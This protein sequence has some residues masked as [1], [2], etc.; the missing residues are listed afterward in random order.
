MWR[1]SIDRPA[2]LL[3]I[4][5]VAVC[6]V[7]LVVIAVVTR[8][9]VDRLRMLQQQIEH[10]S[11]IQRMALRVQRSLLAHPDAATNGDSSPFNAL[12]V[13]LLEL[14]ARGRALD[15]TS[16]ERLIRL[17]ELLAVDPTLDPARLASAVALV[18]EIVEA[19]ISAQ[20]DLWARIN[21]DTQLELA[22]V[23]ALCIVLP[24][25]A[26]LAAVFIRRRILSPLDDLQGLLSHLSEGDFSPWQVENGHPAFAPVVANYNHLVSRLEMLE[27]EHRSRAES[28]EAEVR[29]ATQTL[30]DQQ[31]TLSR[32]ERLAAV[33]ETT[34]SLAHELRNPLA[35]VLMS[36]GNLRREAS[37]GDVIERLDLVIAEVERLTRLLNSALSEAQHTPEPSRRLN[38]RELVVSLLALL[39]Y[40]IPD[41]I[42][43]VCNIQDDLECSLPRDRIRQALLNLVINSTRAIGENP[44][45]VTVDATSNDDR[46][47][48]T[49]EDDGPGFPEDLLASGIRPFTSRITGGTGLG[50]AMVR[51][52]ALDLGG[53]VHLKNLRPRG[54]Q[55][56]LVVPCTDG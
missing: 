25:M 10:S 15:R 30:L 41:H 27:R 52:V 5:L 16:D 43:L 33:G 4:G 18:D 54:A 24:A 19:E 36:L 42:D 8:R 26:V 12:R 21:A 40:Q 3:A 28:L 11:R 22:T 35:G 14:R 6:L 9:D 37:D 38:L 32:A 1:R 45:R 56:R 17:H 46:I 48:L 34:A 29:S 13:E 31:S 53:E 51:R 39:R 7:S 44:G 23:L 49:V 20:S 55:V 47:E 50:L 2:Q